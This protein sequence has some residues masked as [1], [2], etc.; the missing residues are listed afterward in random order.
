MTATTMTAEERIRAVAAA[1]TAEERAA[2]FGELRQ[3]VAQTGGVLLDS[4]LT[5]ELLALAE[6]LGVRV[7]WRRVE[8]PSYAKD[9]TQTASARRGRRKVSR[10]R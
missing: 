6:H 4:D 2:R 7:E 9:A 3:M 5:L 8:L 1:L 10:R